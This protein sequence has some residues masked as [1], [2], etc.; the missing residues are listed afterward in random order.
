MGMDN[1]EK[2]RH[3]ANLIKSADAVVVGAGS[4]LSSA[5]GYNHYHWTLELEQYLREFRV[6]Y[7]FASPFAGFY[8]CYSSLEEQ[9]AYYTKYIY[10]M[11]HL[12]VGQPYLDLYD[13]LFGKEYFILTTNVDMQCDRVFSPEQICEFQGNMGYF[14]C[15]QPC[16]DKRYENREIIEKMNQAV[17]GTFLPSEWIPRCPECGRIMVPWVR[18]DTFLE[19]QDWRSA[20]ERYQSFLM[21]YL[22]D[23]TEKNVLLLELGVGE[24]TP[25]VIKL[26]F[27]DMTSRNKG[28]FYACLNREASS[29]PEHIKDRS[30]Y[31]QGNLAEILEELRVEIGKEKNDG[32]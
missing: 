9:W 11:W 24:M 32:E 19:G 30:M 16:H 6:Y 2:I 5:A 20:V 22:T 1:S 26:P 3:L 14:Q 23:Q 8:H 17:C 27:W 12:P 25:G 4:G 28:V 7:Q 13:I 15:S 31:L 29:A 21:K 10:S 18:D